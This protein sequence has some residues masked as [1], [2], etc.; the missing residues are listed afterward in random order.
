MNFKVLKSAVLATSLLVC[1]QASAAFITINFSGT[2]ASNANNYYLARIVFD[3]TIAGTNGNNTK[4]GVVD[5]KMQTFGAHQTSFSLADVSGFY[6]LNAYGASPL[7]Q[8]LRGSFDG[9]NQRAWIALGVNNQNYRIALNNYIYERM[10]D[11]NGN[12][13]VTYV[14][15]KVGTRQALPTTPAAAVSAPSTLAIFALGLMGLVARRFKK[16]A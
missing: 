12:L 1:Q 15:D 7:T 4:A 11:K 16:S 13:V 14:N 2:D 9:S 5:F 8:P 6:W 10:L 3:N